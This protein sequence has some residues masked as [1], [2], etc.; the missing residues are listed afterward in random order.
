MLLRSGKVPVGFTAYGEEY[1]DA[2]VSMASNRPRSDVTFFVKNRFRGETKMS[3]TITTTT[4]QSRSSDPVVLRHRQ[5]SRKVAGKCPFK[6]Y[7]QAAIL[8]DDEAV[9]LP[10]ERLG[11]AVVVRDADVTWVTMVAVKAK[12]TTHGYHSLWMEMAKT[13]WDPAT[14]SPTLNGPLLAGTDVMHPLFAVKERPMCQVGLAMATAYLAEAA[15]DQRRWPTP[16]LGFQA[17]EFDQVFA[18]LAHPATKYDARH[19]TAWR[20]EINWQMWSADGM[21]VTCPFS[22][23]VTGV[24]TGDKF[25]TVGFDAGDYGFQQLRLPKRVEV[26]LD[27]GQSVE[28]GNAMAIVRRHLPAARDVR[29]RDRWMHVIETVGHRRELYELVKTWFAS[30]CLW[31]GDGLVYA[32]V[33]LIPVGVDA[34]WIGDKNAVWDISDIAGLDSVEEL[35]PGDPMMCPPLRAYNGHQWKG[36][37]P[38]GV[39]YNLTPDSYQAF[40]PGVWLD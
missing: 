31:P 19:P 2:F 18:K 25:T 13:G 20:D 24:E 21:T 37:T 35:E 26:L 34:P 29:V 11:G 9:F 39:T 15:P 38:S 23:V 28:R 14:G 3:E 16:Y 33:S 1:G 10:P 36:R 30:V 5:L 40:V 8:L 12:A 22:A 4:T 6:G 32:P 27:D 7:H 17:E